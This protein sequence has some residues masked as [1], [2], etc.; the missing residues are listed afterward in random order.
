M[1]DLVKLSFIVVI[2]NHA[3]LVPNGAALAISTPHLA[4]LQR[5]MPK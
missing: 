2:I 5:F 3:E 1:R 4:L